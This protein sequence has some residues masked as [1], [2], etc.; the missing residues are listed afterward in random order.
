MNQPNTA[1]KL[2]DTIRITYGTHVLKII[3]DR[4]TLGKKLAHW[5]NHRIFNLRCLSKGI[6]PVSLRIRPPDASA[7]SLHAARVA[8]RRFLRQ[9][10]HLCSMKINSIRG[11]IGQL[12]AIIT[13]ELHGNVLTDLVD[14]ITRRF[15]YI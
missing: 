15:C 12:M 1:P 14:L 13:R 6:I 5:L 10:I 4:L 8:S 7:R 9:R 2:F 11:Q 3:N